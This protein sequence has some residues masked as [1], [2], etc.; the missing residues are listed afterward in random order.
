[1]MQ[2]QRSVSPRRCPMPADGPSARAS[3]GGGNGIVLTL[4]VAMTVSLSGCVLAPS[5]T[6]GEK[7][8]VSQVSQSFEAPIESR[9]LPELPAPAS[10]SDILS[11]AFLANGELEAAYFEWKAALARIDQAAVWPNSNVAVSFGYMFSPENVKAWNRTTIG[12]GFDPAMNLSFPIKARTAGEVAELPRQPGR[13]S[14]AGVAPGPDGWRC[15][16]GDPFCSP[17]TEDLTT[18]SAMRSRTGWG[19]TGRL[20]LDV[21]LVPL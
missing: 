7:E 6:R 2:P 12:V 8:K 18:S 10:W 5:G 21:E 16:T 14:R 15:R 17:Q 1:M 13:R 19:L 9:Q 20:C 4:A 3:A 11:R